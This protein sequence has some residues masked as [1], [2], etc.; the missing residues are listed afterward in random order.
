MCTLTDDQLKQVVSTLE[1]TKSDT[2]KELEQIEKDC[3]NKDNSNAPLEEG[4]GQYIS[5]GVIMPVNDEEENDEFSDLDNIDIDV[6]GLLQESIKSEMSNKFDLSDEDTLKFASVINRVRANEDFNVYKELPDPIK[7]NINKAMDEEGIAKS[8]RYLYLNNFARM[9]IEEIISDS[10]FNALSIDLEKA[11]GEVLPTPLEMYSETNRD[12]IEN[13]FLEV[14]EKI[15]EEDPIRAQNLINMRLGYI[16]AYKFDNMYDILDNTNVINKIRK[17]SK[18]WNRID[19]EYK[20]LAGKCKFKLYPL[21]ETKNDLIKIGLSKE[22][23]EKLCALFVYTYIED[24]DDITDET[25]YNDIY[26]N[27]FANYFEMNMRNLALM[28]TPVTDFSKEIKDNIVKL[29]SYI[30]KRVS[31]R[32]TELLNNK[33]KRR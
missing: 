4:T 23:S 13:K 30:D 3:N 17:A 2:D 19:N 20:L 11:M 5:D 33:K 32:E 31:E 12:Y 25:I 9:L 15:K 29:S 22:S 27:S 8:D 10:E 28:K 1:E 18:S 14:A 21:N 6:E 7:E 16:H 24:A 26:R